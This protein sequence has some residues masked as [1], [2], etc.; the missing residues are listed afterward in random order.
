MVVVE[1]WIAHL[2]A[3]DFYQYGACGF[4]SLIPSHMYIVM[5]VLPTGYV[6]D[7]GDDFRLVGA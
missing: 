3:Y 6:V 4:A 2:D 7:E 5:F 1:F